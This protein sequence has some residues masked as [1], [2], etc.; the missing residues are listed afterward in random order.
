MN[1]SRFI[2]LRFSVGSSTER[3]V[4]FILPAH[5][6]GCK[7]EVA[8]GQSITFSTASISAP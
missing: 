3:A 8:A 6:A 1:S 2:L 7:G 5:I 4:P